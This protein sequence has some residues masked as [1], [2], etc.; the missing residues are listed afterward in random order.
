MVAVTFIFSLNLFGVFEML[1]PSSAIGRM[2]TAGGAGIAGSFC[3][4]VFATLLATPC[5]APFLGTA[6][7]FA[8]GAPLQELWLIFLVLGL[9][10]ALPWLFVAIIPKTATLLPRPGRWMNTLKMVLGAM[11]LASS[12]WL[13][14]LLSLHLGETSSAMITLALILAALLALLVTGKRTTPTF[15]LVV[16]ALAAL[17]SYQVRGL[18]ANE[19]A[20]SSQDTTAQHI[21]WQPLSEDAILSALADGKRV[22]VDISADWCVTCKV[23]E[24]RVLNQP[25]IISALSQP[26]VVALRGDWSKP[27]DLITRFLQKRNSYAIPF[28]EVY[29]PGSPQGVMLPPLLDQQTVLDALNHAKG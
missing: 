22:F 21:R 26:D 1:L 25:A 23:N 15:W 18:L 6:V 24:H 7:A 2:A 20:L 9:G 8:L 3:E 12:F 14:T 19:A 17:G 16:I 11:M 13:A 5:S 10:M 29:G 4:G 27:S 28:N